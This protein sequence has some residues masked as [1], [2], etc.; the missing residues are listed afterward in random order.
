MTIEKQLIQKVYY[1]TFLT[2]QDS[3]QSPQ[4]LGEAYVNEAENEFSNIANIRFAQG[5]VYYHHKDFETAIFKWEKV[6]NDLSL[7]AKKNI[8]DAYFELGLLLCLIVS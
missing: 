4:V 2:E 8:A 1:E 7:W 3:V 5:E 6:N